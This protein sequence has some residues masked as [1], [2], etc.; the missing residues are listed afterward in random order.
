[1]LKKTE[2]SKKKKTKK[3]Y[4]IKDWKLPTDPWLITQEVPAKVIEVS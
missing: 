3:Q 1:M 4:I 2:I